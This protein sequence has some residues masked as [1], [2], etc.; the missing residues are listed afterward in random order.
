MSALTDLILYL[1]S[2]I[3]LFTFADAAVGRTQKQALSR[4]IFGQRDMDFA[5]FETTLIASLL[6]WFR[7]RR[8]RF[9]LW[10][11][12]VYSVVMILFTT[13]M[14]SSGAMSVILGGP[15]PA[16]S[17]DLNLIMIAVFLALGVASLPFDYWSLIITARVFEGNAIGTWR[18]PLAVLLDIVA[19]SLPF[20]VV[21]VL[22]YFLIT[23]PLAR[24]EPLPQPIDDFSVFG[25][26]GMFFSYLSVVY[27]SLIQISLFAVGLLLRG[28]ALVLTGLSRVAEG[29]Q[30]A[31][32]PITT[33]GLILGIVSYL[34]G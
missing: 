16:G 32:H 4:Y 5:G 2:F 31:N 21:G 12:Y 19:S 17:I 1:G 27:V 29:S 33:V 26:V 6:G 13:V 22:Y 18:Y 30:I 15:P 8:G 24:G 11:V 10:R 23:L 20:I 34:S 9:A 28:M 7:N 25:L 14:L 3:A